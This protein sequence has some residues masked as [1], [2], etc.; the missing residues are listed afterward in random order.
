M[1]A[2][3]AAMVK[4]RAVTVMVVADEEIALWLVL[5][6]FVAVTVQVVPTPPVVDSVLPDN[7]QPAVPAFVTA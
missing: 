1:V 4:V 2:A 5:A 3:T 6:A 7:E